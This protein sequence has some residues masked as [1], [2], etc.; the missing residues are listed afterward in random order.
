MYIH[1]KLVY[2][3]SPNW[4]TSRGRTT[5]QFIINESLQDTQKSYKK[6][7][8]RTNINLSHFSSFNPLNIF[9]SPKMFTL[10]F[11]TIDPH[12]KPSTKNPLAGPLCDGVVSHSRTSK[13]APQH[14]SHD[15]LFMFTL[16]VPTLLV[17]EP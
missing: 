14:K 4:S 7:V 1:T 12:H 8:S 15:L 17:L 16:L 5:F 10:C 2:P 11:P 3:F 9:Y 13:G 6:L